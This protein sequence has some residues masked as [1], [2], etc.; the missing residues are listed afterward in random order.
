MSL[1]IYAKDGVAEWVKTVEARLSGFE[2]YD[3][4]RAELD[5]LKLA[6]RDLE[7]TVDRAAKAMGALLGK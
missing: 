1:H 6:V 4:L 5:E 2:G 3:G 7:A